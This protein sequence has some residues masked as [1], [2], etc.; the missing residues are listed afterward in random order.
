MDLSRQAK[1]VLAALPKA[2][3]RTDK[4]DILRVYLHP[5]KLMGAIRQL[6][7][8][9]INWSITNLASEGEIGCVTAPA[10]SEGDESDELAAAE[11]LARELIRMAHRL[12]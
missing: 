5:E 7:D 8:G 2:D 3:V 12:L 4:C 11:C 6:T 9:R 10:K 1:V